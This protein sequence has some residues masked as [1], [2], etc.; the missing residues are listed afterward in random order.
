[1]KV[2]RFADEK[3]VIRWGVVEGDIIKETKGLQ[4]DFT[5]V[6]FPFANIQLLAPAEPTK[7]ICVG[8]NYVDHIEEMDGDAS[9][10]P[11]EPGLF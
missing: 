6:D 10:L 8:K 9:R 7:I 5:G 3:G 11:T 1:M 4:G 2:A